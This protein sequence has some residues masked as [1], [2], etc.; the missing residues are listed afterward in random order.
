MD[1]NGVQKMKM[2]GWKIFYNRWS[3]GSGHVKPIITTYHG[4]Y[5]LIIFS[6]DLLWWLGAYTQ[7]LYQRQQ[8]IY[9][10]KVMTTFGCKKMI[11]LL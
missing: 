8:E 1:N 4:L 9:I 5:N 10:E 11:N 3:V 6:L 2:F 7:M